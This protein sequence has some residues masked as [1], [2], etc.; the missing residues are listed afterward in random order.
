MSNCYVVAIHQLLNWCAVKHHYVAGLEMS[1]MQQ[2]NIIVPIKSEKRASDISEQVVPNQCAT[3]SLRRFLIVTAEQ[4]QR[5][6]R[7]LHDGVGELNVLQNGPWRC[8]CLIPH[9]T[10]NGNARL[11]IRPAVLKHITVDDYVPGVFQLQQ[12]LYSPV[13]A[14]IGGVP[15][16]P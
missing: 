4:F 12:I 1:V 15:N 5:A 10:Q 7:S 14:R 6:P 16:L 2:A 8:P 13:C 11:S 3:R 9:R